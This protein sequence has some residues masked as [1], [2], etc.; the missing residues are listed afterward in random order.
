MRSR[1]SH[2]RRL[3]FAPSGGRSSKRP[4][5]T[6]SMSGGWGACGRSLAGVTGAR[7]SAGRV[8]D[9]EREAICDFRVPKYARRELPDLLF[10]Y[11]ESDEF[12][13]TNDVGRGVASAHA[14]GLREC[15]LR[16]RPIPPADG[17]RGAQGSGVS[18]E[19]AGVDGTPRFLNVKHLLP[20]NPT[21]TENTAKK[22][23]IR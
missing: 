18:S 13:G 7:F 21:N 22:A 10:S 23:W 8:T 5:V 12:C 17:S 4:P 1:T 20:M 9:A 2:S 16:L 11:F 14:G 19:Q 6:V 15:R 3:P